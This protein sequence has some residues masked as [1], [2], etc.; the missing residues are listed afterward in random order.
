MSGFDAPTLHYPRTT[1]LPTTQATSTHRQHFYNF[2]KTYTTRRGLYKYRDALR[3]NILAGTYALA[4]NVGEFVEWEE[5]HAE[6]ETT[7]S[8]EIVE[9]PERMIGFVSLQ[10]S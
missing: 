9:A 6:E 1:S 4:I 8:G 3:A 7:L 2:Y 10:R 5:Q